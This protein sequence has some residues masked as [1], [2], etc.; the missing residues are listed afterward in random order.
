M[1]RKIYKIILIVKTGLHIGSGNDQFKIGGIDSYVVKD[2]ISK[3][4]YIPGSSLKGKIRSLLEIEKN[5]FKNGNPSKTGEVAEVFGSGGDK[6][7]NENKKYTKVIFRDA[8]LTEEWKKKYEN[9]EIEN[10]I[11]AEVSIDRLTGTASGAGPR[12]I[13]RV[14]KDVQFEIEIILRGETD[15]DLEKSLKLIKEGFELLKNDYLGGSGSRGYGAV[16]IL[17]L[18]EKK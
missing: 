9:E 3:L 4:P 6:T 17:E 16:E 2:P 11:K 15:D 1:K 14:P 18:V 12:F 5:L 13:E 10:E 7:E 8:H